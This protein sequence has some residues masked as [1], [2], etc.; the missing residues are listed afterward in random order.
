MCARLSYAHNSLTTTAV[1]QA[2][3]VSLQ[4]APGSSLSP[5]PPPPGSAPPC[6]RFTFPSSEALQLAR[7]RRRLRL[8]ARDAMRHL[9]PEYDILGA[10]RVRGRA[11]FGAAPCELRREDGL[12]GRC[13][14]FVQGDGEGTLQA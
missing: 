6:P 13:V 12:R 5:P 3:A 10:P 2:R 9:G 1:A 14:A 8:R 11:R 7:G 4:H